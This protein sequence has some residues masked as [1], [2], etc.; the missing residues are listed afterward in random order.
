M[1]TSVCHTS[2]LLICI[3]QV[4]IWALRMQLEE[5]VMSLSVTTDVGFTPI[6][7]IFP[8]WLHF[9][10][11]DSYFQ[12]CLAP[13]SFSMLSIHAIEAFYS[14]F[15]A[16]LANICAWISHYSCALG[17]IWCF[18]F[19]TRWALGVWNGISSSLF[20]VI[21]VSIFKLYLIF[22]FI[23]NLSINISSCLWRQKHQ[24]G[25]LTVANL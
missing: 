12:T 16:L 10:S 14:Y 20:F 19:F 25:G 3:L 9:S 4:A 13:R 5:F 15:L 23:I 22:Y 11:L 8:H 24:N 17:M 1:E 2:I 7:H 18:I 21:F 6:M